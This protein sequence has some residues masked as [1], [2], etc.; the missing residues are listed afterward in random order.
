M[1]CL[2]H[3]YRPLMTIIRLKFITLIKASYYSWS[4]STF[5]TAYYQYYYIYILDSL[6]IN[7]M[8]GIIKSLSSIYRKYRTYLDVKMLSI[9]HSLTFSS[10]PGFSL[11]SA[12]Y[13]IWILSTQFNFIYLW[14]L[15]TQFNF[16]SLDH[17]Q[18]QFNIYFLSNHSLTFTFFSFFHLLLILDSKQAFTV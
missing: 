16:I 9:P 18:P 14:I 13:Y 8:D 1:Y 4:I 15:W 3:N 7:F 12:F 6:L 10:F 2:L 5:Y 11:S 17:K